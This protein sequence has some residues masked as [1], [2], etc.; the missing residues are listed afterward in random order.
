METEIKIVEYIKGY[1]SKFGPWRDTK[2]MHFYNPLNGIV[3]NFT[4][5]STF[6]KEI[7][8][9]SLQVIDNEKIEELERSEEFFRNR[10]SG[11]SSNSVQV[12]KGTTEFE[13]FDDLV[14]LVSKVKIDQ[15]ELGGLI[16]IGKLDYNPMD[17]L[18]EEFLSGL[19]DALSTYDMP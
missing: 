3:V 6:Y 17:M 14:R 9:A 7:L 5:D 4:T 8:N 19:Y 11:S 1:S 13:Q 10:A 16:K 12:R 2:N 15:K 18:L